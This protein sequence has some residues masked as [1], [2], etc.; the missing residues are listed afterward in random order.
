MTDYRLLN[1]TVKGYCDNE[2]AAIPLLSN[3]SSIIFDEL[4]ELNWAGFYLLR[5]KES[6]KYSSVNFMDSSVN[7]EEYELVVGPFQGKPACIRIPM[8]K[9][10]CG[11]AAFCMETQRIED[12]HTF[13]GH[14]AC[15]SASNSE[16]VIPL[17]KEGKVYGV[18]DID[19][20]KLS[21]FAKEDE[22]G[23]KELAEY[24]N[25]AIVP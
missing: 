21:R 24:I 11:T 6:K 3:V 10:V 25:Q 2:P 9:G 23:L 16:I 15:D 8:G 19:S 14:I 13:P 18:L 1:D 4:E 5:N 17:I 7:K 20:P 12:V 22:E